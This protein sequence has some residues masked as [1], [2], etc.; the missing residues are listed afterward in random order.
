M[1][2]VESGHTSIE[3]ERAVSDLEKLLHFG[4]DLRYGGLVAGFALEDLPVE[5]VSILGDPES[6]LDLLVPSLAAGSIAVLGDDALG[7]FHVGGGDVVYEPGVCRLASASEFRVE[8]GHYPILHLRQT[9]EV[10]VDLVI[11]FRRPRNSQE[12]GAR[13]SRRPF[14]NAR[15]ACRINRPVQDQEFGVA[16]P[17]Q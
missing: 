5:G 1:E 3:D 14:E 12:G 2:V 7:S 10:A 4:D 15:L 16:Y 9:V 17:A 11:D 8:M 13:R 6:D